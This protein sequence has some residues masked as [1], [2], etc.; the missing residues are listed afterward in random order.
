LS[1]T[2]PAVIDPGSFRPNCFRARYNF[3]ERVEER[4]ASLKKP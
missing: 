3:T 4:F 1:M 2:S